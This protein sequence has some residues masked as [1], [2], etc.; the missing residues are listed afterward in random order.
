MNRIRS[1]TRYLIIFMLIAAT[2]SALAGKGLLVKDNIEP[3]KMRTHC[4]GRYQID[5]PEE[6]TKTPDSHVTLYFGLDKNFETVEIQNPRE[7]GEIP[8]LSRLVGAEKAELLAD[9]DSRFPSKTRL[10]AAKELDRNSVLV[11]AYDSPYLIDSLEL[12]LFVQRG[13]AIARLKNEKFSDEVNSTA[14]SHYESQLVRIA[15]NTRYVATPQQ[16]G[17]SSCLGTLAIDD[18]QDGEVYSVSFLSEKHPDIVISINM[19]SL[20]EKGDGGLLARVS[21]K[22]ALLRALDFSS[23][24]L[25]KG[26]RKIAGRP[27]EELL[28]EGKQEGKIQRYFVAETLVTEP[29]SLNRPVIAINMSMGGQDRKT[30]AYVDP[31]LS[32]KEALIWWDSIVDSIRLR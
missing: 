2:A 14:L 20:T 7:R 22:A 32:E 9:E 12:S 27:G 6:F 3:P 31:S 15:S 23:S 21:G 8:A 30:R 17:R 28:D 18:K 4:I 11:V 1:S 29:S 10:A 13:E 16:A 25:R 5:L 19:N 24:T 26:K